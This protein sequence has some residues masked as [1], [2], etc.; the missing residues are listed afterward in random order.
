MTPIKELPVLV[1]PASRPPFERRLIAQA[2]HQGSQPLS[3][4]QFGVGSTTCEL[5]RQ[6]NALLFFEP[7]SGH[8]DPPRTTCRF[9]DWHSLGSLAQ[10]RPLPPEPV[11][12]PR[13]N[14]RVHPPLDSNPGRF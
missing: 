12:V 8:I 6:V 11:G 7:I 5:G 1:T 9:D 3:C 14:T 10:S 4:D 2:C 13:E